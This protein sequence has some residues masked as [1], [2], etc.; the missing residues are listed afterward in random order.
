MTTA[1]FCLLLFILNLTLAL[2]AGIYEIRIVLPLWF[3]RQADGSILV[4]AA[5]M[6]QTD[7]G[8]RFWGMITTVPLTVLTLINLC[9]AL[10]TGAHANAWWLC[11]ALLILA[12]RLATFAFFIPAAIALQSNDALS[13]TGK[14]RLAMQWLRYNYLR[15][16]AMGIGVLLCLAAFLSL[17]R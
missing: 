13:V 9:Y 6:R 11:G 3:V 2:G 16:W 5:F 12:E 8:R 1:S 14:S 4:D 10:T 7:V 17:S 15:N